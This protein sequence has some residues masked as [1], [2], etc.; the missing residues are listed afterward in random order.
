MFNE[1]PYP[2]EKLNCFLGHL[3]YFFHPILHNHTPPVHFFALVSSKLP[4]K[5]GLE[6]GDLWERKETPELSI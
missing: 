6:D 2:F 4:D 3:F 5:Q 1:I